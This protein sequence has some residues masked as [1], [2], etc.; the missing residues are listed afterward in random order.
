MRGA[1]SEARKMVLKEGSAS[2]PVT[3]FEEYP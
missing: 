3:T 2:A 1:V